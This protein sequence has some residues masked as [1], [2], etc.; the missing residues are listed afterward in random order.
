MKEKLKKV[1]LKWKILWLDQ[2]VVVKIP[3]LKFL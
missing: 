3:Y 1:N 2:G